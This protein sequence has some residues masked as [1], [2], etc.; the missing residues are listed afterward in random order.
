MWEYPDAEIQRIAHEV[1]TPN[2]KAPEV[3]NRLRAYIPAM[4]GA[5][6]QKLGAEAAADGATVLWVSMPPIEDGTQGRRTYEARRDLA[7]AAGMIPLSVRE[8]YGRRDRATLQIAPWDDH[9]NVA[10]HRLIAEALYREI[11]R[12]DREAGLQITR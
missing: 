2:A 8:A 9:P 12:A 3:E 10:G 5:L 4:T 6:F 11:L 1:W 7:V